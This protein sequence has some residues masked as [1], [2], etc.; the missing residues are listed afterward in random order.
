MDSQALA[1]PRLFFLR[2]T[3]SLSTLF[4]AKG[5]DETTVNWTIEYIV[6]CVLSHSVFFDSVTHGLYLTKL[7]CPWESPGKNVIC[8]VAQSCLTLCDPMD[9]SKPGSSI[10]GDSP[11]KNI[12]MC[13]HAL[14]QGIFPTQGSNPGLQHCRQILYHMSHQGSKNIGADCHF[15]F[16]EICRWHHHY[17]KKWRTKEPLDESEK[18]EWKNWLKP[19]HSKN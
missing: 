5:Q 1:L 7:L 18:G 14:L 16:Q 13:C 19:Q 12:G 2:V 8:L 3:V 15:L 6:A 4:A 11:G 10:H 17:G 9:C